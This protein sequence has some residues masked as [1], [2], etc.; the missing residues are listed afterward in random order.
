MSSQIEES[1]T[2]EDNVLKSTPP[3]DNPALKKLR[4]LEQAFN[5]ANEETTKALTV[6]AEKKL[7]H[8]HA[9]EI[10]LGKTKALTKAQQDF[11]L[12]KMA[13]YEANQTILVQKLKDANVPIAIN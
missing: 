8:T 7:E 1:K 9:I 4:E 12:T 2:E 3:Q 11:F 10:L 13:L 6:E 5:K